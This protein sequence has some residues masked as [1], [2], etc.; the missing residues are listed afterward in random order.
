MN[1][2]LK[3]VLIVG[4][5]LLIVG[6]A[7]F[8]AAALMGA[9]PLSVFD[10]GI[11]VDGSGVH[12]GGVNVHTGEDGVSVQVGG[13]DVTATG[14]TPESDEWT[15]FYEAF[16]GDG[17]DDLFTVY[18]ETGEYTCPASTDK[19]D[20]AWTAGSVTV[21]PYD[22]EEITLKETLRS[23]GVA[24]KEDAMGW[25]I[26]DGVLYI[27]YSS[28]T[29]QTNLPVKDLTVLLPRAMA[30]KLSELELD[31]ASADMSVKDVTCDELSFDSAS[32]SLTASGITARSADTETVSGD[33]E[34]VGAIT[35]L[36]ADATSG[37]VRAQT[38]VSGAEADAETVSGDIELTGF[39]R[40]ETSTTS[41]TA[42]VESPKAQFIRADSISGDV[43]LRLAADAAF[44]LDYDTISGELDCGYATMQKGGRYVCGGGGAEIEVGTTSGS[45]TVNPA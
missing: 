1:K 3:I 9:S 16:S 20:I 40:V 17:W 13:N 25:G 22:G 11:Y 39:V 12:V 27:R 32:G 21:E 7:L 4:G 35:K 5:A 28:K 38:T 37:L 18:S 8:G 2:T 31:T 26:R 33:V 41:G 34:L 19:V 24:E 23:G 15:K 43:E 14:A 45:L 6:A 30:A 29:V 10:R 44:T 42:T 36:D